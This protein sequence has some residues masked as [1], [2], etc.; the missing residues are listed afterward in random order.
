M[1]GSNQSAAAARVAGLKTL[2]STR[3]MTMGLLETLADE[4]WLAQPCADANH[5]AWVV[6]H[7]ALSDHD[8][9]ESVHEA[10]PALPESWKGIFGMKSK[11]STD[12]SVYPSRG[13]LMSALGEQRAA[14]IAGFE[15]LSDERLLEPIE[16]EMG[17]FIY[18]RAVMMSFAAAHE[19][20]HVGQVAVVRRSL[21]ME[22]MF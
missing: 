8:F 19:W 9:A 10:Q 21:G 16:G 13:E 12:A 18:N 14:L 5:A 22:P 20:F 6:G 2:E 3:Q 7:L 17:Q 11:P 1:T 15:A 4:H